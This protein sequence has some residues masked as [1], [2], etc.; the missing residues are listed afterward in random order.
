MK[1]IHFYITEDGDCPVIEFLDSLTAKQAQKVTWVLKLIEELEDI[2]T[3]YLKKL[4]NTDG[5]WEVRAQAGNN[6]FRLLGFLT[7]TVLLF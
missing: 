2:P 6:I 7:K 5:I 3:T 1:T 4:V